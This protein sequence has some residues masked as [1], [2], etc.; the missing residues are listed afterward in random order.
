[1]QGNQFNELC[2]QSGSGKEPLRLLEGYG[3]LC[4]AWGSA[5]NCTTLLHPPSRWGLAC[6]HNYLPD[7]YV[8]P[9]GDTQWHVHVQK[10]C[11]ADGLRGIQVLENRAGCIQGKVTQ[12]AG[13]WLVICSDP[14]CPWKITWFQDWF[15][16]WGRGFGYTSQM[17]CAALD[18]PGTHTAATQPRS[19][20]VPCPRA[21]TLSGHRALLCWGRG[22][23]QGN[24]SPKQQ[25]GH[26]VKTEKMLLRHHFYF[27]FAPPQGS[28]ETIRVV[29]MD[30]DYHVECY[31]CEVSPG[32]CPPAPW[33]VLPLGG[34]ALPLGGPWLTPWAALAGSC[35]RGQVGLC[36]TAP[37]GRQRGEC[38]PGWKWCCQY[39]IT[40]GGF[41][42]QYINFKAGL[43]LLGF[44]PSFFDISHWWSGLAN[45]SQ[46][47]CGIRSQF[48]F[49]F[50][51]WF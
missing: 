4:R 41:F 31:H 34:P 37:G 19:G 42:S 8:S 39:Q 23:P 35:T 25:A 29:S 38:C 32:L 26:W 12:W 44:F 11:A 7:W 28:E 1:M 51:C 46:D 6:A 47:L 5:R 22:V 10:S 40:F 48:G 16:P 2:L 9:C 36:P 27:L 24:S 30:K 17:T 45:M 15:V 3:L 33:Q 20:A 14:G 18:V 21:K 13:F 50:S 43:G 49:N